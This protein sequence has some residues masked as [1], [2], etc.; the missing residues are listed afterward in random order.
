V[1]WEASRGNRRLTGWSGFLDDCRA[2]RCKIF[3]VSTGAVYD[4]ANARDWKTMADEGV[5][6]QAESDRLSARAKRGYDAAWASGK[7]TGR[8]AYGLA[9][10]YDSVTRE[11]IEQYP[12]EETAPVVREIISAIAASTP[13][14]AI[15]ADL[16]R[17]GIVSPSGQPRWSRNSVIRLVKDGLVYIAKRRGADG[18]LLA[19][20]WEPLVSE[21]V[22][23]AAR[24]LLADPARKAQADRRGGVRPGAARWMASYIATCGRCGAP[25]NVVSRKAGPVYRCESSAAG[26][27]SAPVEWLDSLIGEAVIAWSSRPEIFAALTVSDSS[28][29]TA[30]RGEAA[31]ARERL[32]GLEAQCAAGEISGVSFARM[33]SLIE[34]RIAELDSVTSRN[35]ISPALAQLLSGAEHSDDRS[36]VIRAM[37]LTMELA[38]RRAVIRALADVTLAPTSPEHAAD[39]PFRVGIA[40][41][42]G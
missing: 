18:T 15:V 5:S 20:N 29:A 21:E 22:F 12:D 26:C 36:A 28:E 16:Y 1:L 37:W 8:C 10:K 14:S 9:R 23:F 4:V 17:R 7:P 25:L 42:T 31:A 41:H 38:G 11:L 2:A 24:R 27:A 30:A 3:V 35:V 39:D 19:G 13:I 40:W 6:S 34:A 32:E 33:A